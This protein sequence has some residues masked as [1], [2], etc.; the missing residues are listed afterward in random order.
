VSPDITK[1]RERITLTKVGLAKALENTGTV[2]GYGCP[3]KLTTLMYAT[4]LDRLAARFT[5]IYDDNPLKV[6][7]STPGTRIPIVPSAT[8]MVDPPDTLVLFAWN[9]AAEIIPRLRA[10][11]YRGRIVTPLPEVEIDEV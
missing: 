9:F 2:A 7:R 8:L 6:G 3:A 1:L 5:C 11:G 4:G 10:N